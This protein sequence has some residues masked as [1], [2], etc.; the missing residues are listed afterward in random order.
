MVDNSTSKAPKNQAFLK[1][2][3]QQRLNKLCN[4]VIDLRGKVAGE[5]Q[6]YSF[7]GKTHYLDDR[8]Y[9]IAKQLLDRF[10]G[11]YTVGVYEALLK[12]LKKLS[13][14]TQVT[15]KTAT[16]AILTSDKEHVQLI[17]FDSQLQRKE[18]RISFSTPV[19]IHIADVL[20]HAATIDITT[21]SIR[22]SLKRAYTLEQGDMVAV[23]LPE[24]S[25]TLSKVAYK[26]IKITHDDLH[27]YLI[28]ARNRQDDHKVTNWFDRWSQQH[29]TPEH[30]DLDNELFN[31]ASV[32]YLRLYCQAFTSSFFWLNSN[33]STNTLQTCHMTAMANESLQVLRQDDGAFDL[34][35]L[36][37]H[38]VL[39]QQSAQLVLIT[40]QAE[41][42]T[43]TAASCNNAPAVAALLSWHSQQQDSQVLLLQA[44][45]L[46]TDIQSFASEI[47]VIAKHNSDDAQAFQQCLTNITTLITVN[48]ITSSC[49]HLQQPIKADRPEKTEFSP[50]INA[51]K[52]T[53]LQ[54]NTDREN[55]RFFIKTEVTVNFNNQ[56]FTITTNDVSESGLALSLT[57]NIDIQQGARLFI[58]FVRWQTLTKEVKLHNVPYIVR[59]SHFWDGETHLGLQRDSR[60]CA[61]SINKF[62]TTAIE[63]NKEQLVENNTH[64][65]ISQQSQVFASLLSAQ[66]TAI[67]LYFGM[68]KE[69]KRIL[70]AVAT[71]DGNLALTKHDLWLSLQGS[72]TAIAELIK[73]LADNSESYISFGLYCYQDNNGRWHINSEH[74]F[75]NA[76]QKSLFINQALLHQHHH[77]FHCSISAL[78]LNAMAEEVDLVQQL[79]QLRN[80]SQHKVKQIREVLTKLFAV[81]EL[82]DITALLTAVYR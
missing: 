9:L 53:N 34:S 29:N 19:D 33:D 5:C 4:R 43:S 73:P 48:N 58:E 17:A 46:Q 30:L 1:Q 61:R 68:D 65:A 45:E 20:Y 13:A 3:D 50:V 10:N 23:S 2:M 21:S 28:L 66:L 41:Q 49:Q 74:D 32:F 40:Q 16:K 56:Q 18:P 77:F 71:T 26:I 8:G 47:A 80:H 25:A 44:T 59:N 22:L 36:P 38:Q 81:G 78:S 60:A 72:I 35:L 39:K 31:L 63:L 11:S 27:S 12:A 82:T 69:N 67:P 54:H 15:N 76:V 57:G 62:F 14:T 64:I 70:Q 79:A 55:Q 75:N 37:L 42:L 52:P 7:G 51:V 6:A 24:L